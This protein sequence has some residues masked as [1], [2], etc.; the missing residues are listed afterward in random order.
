MIKRTM[1]MLTVVRTCAT[2][3]DILFLLVLSSIEAATSCRVATNEAAHSSEGIA[4]TDPLRKNAVSSL[5]YETIDVTLKAKATP[6]PRLVI[7]ITPGNF[8]PGLVDHASTNPLLTKP[9]VDS[10]SEQYQYRID[11]SLNET[12]TPQ[13]ANS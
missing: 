5:L 3:Y 10:A 1:I 6:T 4:R 11:I 8:S 7:A 2:L 13:T 9:M 12:Q